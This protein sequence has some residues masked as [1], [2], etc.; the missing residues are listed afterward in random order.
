MISGIKR[1]MKWTEMYKRRMCL[2]FIFAVLDAICGALPIM[3]AALGLELILAD[4]SKE[5]VLS[6]AHILLTLASL[7]LLILG[8]WLFSYLRSTKQD[9]VAYEVTAEKRLVIGDKLKRLPLGYFKKTRTGELTTTITTELSFFEMMG[10]HMI[11]IVINGYLSITVSIL[12]FLFFEPVVGWISLGGVLMSSIGL[13][14]IQ[15]ISKKNAHKRQE[16]TDKIASATLEYI[17]GMTIV[18]SFK[19]EGAAIK[20]IQE[21][22]R[23]ARKANIKLEL[24][25][26]PPDTLHRFSLYAATTAIILVCAL[27]ALEGAMDLPIMVM[28]IFFS[29]TIFN[30]VEAV[31]NAVLVLEILD[32]NFDKLEKI[33]NAEPIDKNGK[34]IAIDSY[35]IAFE[36]ISF[37]YD[38]NPVIQ[39]VTVLMKQNTMTAI[40]GPSGS[41]KTTL[42][43][44]LARFYDVQEGRITVGGHDVR[45]FTCDS[46]LKNISMVFQNVYLFQDTV[47]NN[48]R[49]GN[50]T[51]SDDAIYEAAKRAC[52]HDFILAMP[53]G[54]DTVIGEGGASLSGGEKQRISIA[55]AMLKDA[56]IIILDE[57]TAS[58]DPENEHF[59]QR[60]ISSLTRG[61]TIITIAH[62][63][64]TIQNADQILVMDEGTIVQR[65]THTELIKQ[66]G[67]YRRFIEIR[68]K[69]ESW[70]I[71]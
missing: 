10:M 11:D 52:C 20:G 71:G 14:W 64:A 69:A 51:A 68:E 42:C 5:A 1:I 58:V 46:L 49:F 57:A 17:R 28:L 70:N 39:N 36:N 60:A 41:G 13:Y 65:G 48:I 55:R 63:L 56:P 61:K 25:Y 62:R 27:K 40:V 45:A 2:G 43:N 8:R 26:S 30:S 16:G 15:K 4:Y 3:V 29:F 47:R 53:R 32:V 38:T 66:Q 44:L 54:Y 59:I 35:D 22:Y 9:S 31:N 18:K 24:D 12:F 37:A 19:Q 7:I 21:A 50:P 33:K 67:V 6:G 34:D 23:A